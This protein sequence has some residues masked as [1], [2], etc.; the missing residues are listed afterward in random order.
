MIS[1]QIPQISKKQDQKQWI[2]DY[3]AKTIVRK[4]AAQFLIY[5]YPKGI[6]IWK[7]NK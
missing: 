3:G 4:T 1:K 6:N 2:I 7:Q 5:Q